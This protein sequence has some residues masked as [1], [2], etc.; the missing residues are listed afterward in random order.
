MLW[1][2]RRLLC[3]LLEHRWG[4]SRVC[5]P[6]W[7]GLPDLVGCDATCARC[8]KPWRDADRYSGERD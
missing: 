3:A 7:R 2:V 8:G 1:L 6:D 4:V 5:N